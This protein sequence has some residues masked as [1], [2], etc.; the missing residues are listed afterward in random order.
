MKTAEEIAR[1]YALTLIDEEF[2][3]GSP[4]YECFL[5]GLKY[6]QSTINQLR[7]ENERLKNQI[8][9]WEKAYQNLLIEKGLIPSN[10]FNYKP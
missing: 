8:E 1:E 9:Q 6:N 7:E 5:A 10:P 3:E 4:Q 2:L